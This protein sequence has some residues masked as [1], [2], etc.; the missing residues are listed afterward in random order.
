VYF[1]LSI[2]VFIFL[3]GIPR[4]TPE[5]LTTSIAYGKDVKLKCFA[6]GRVKLTWYKSK[7]NGTRDDWQPVMNSE[8]SRFVFEKHFRKTVRSLVI[9]KFNVSD[10]GV[11]ICDLYRYYVKWEAHTEKYVGIKGM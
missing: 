3:D 9:K 2:Y 4:P 11:Y 8:E 7:V 10:N 1:Y 5:I 6:I